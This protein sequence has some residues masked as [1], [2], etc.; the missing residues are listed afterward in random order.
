MWQ[1]N[2]LTCS[3]YISLYISYKHL[4]LGA[5]KRPCSRYTYIRS[6]TRIASFGYFRLDFPEGEILYGIAR[7]F[8]Q[9]AT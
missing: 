2:L 9:L 3:T 4:E 8:F 5:C 1:R 6:R 7:A